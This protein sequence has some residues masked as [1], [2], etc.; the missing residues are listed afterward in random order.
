MR[1]GATGNN[2]TNFCNFL[3]IPS[4]TKICGL[5]A[6]LQPIEIYQGHLNLDYAS[7][8]ALHDF[9]TARAEPRT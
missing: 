9:S 8:A 6:P 1:T 2:V 7:F 4:E 5:R 3:E